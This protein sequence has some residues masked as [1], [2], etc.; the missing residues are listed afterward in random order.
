MV[1]TGVAALVIKESEYGKKVLL[2]YRK[3][4]HKVYPECWFLPCG[5]VKLL[6][7]KKHA[8]K[9]ETEEETG[10]VI[11]VKD[12][13]RDELNPSTGIR[14]IAYLC[15]EV[16]GTLKNKEPKKHGAVGYFDID[17][18]PSNTDLV[19]QEIIRPYQTR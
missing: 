4:T 2:I 10:I 3:E 6:E 13:L 11:K 5:H 12:K 7:T 19:V 17:L 8:T 16:S 1:K 15:E 9:R 14:E 18:L